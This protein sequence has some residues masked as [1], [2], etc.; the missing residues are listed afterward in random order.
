MVSFQ[1]S[2]SCT[3]DGILKA[4]DK[5]KNYLKVNEGDLLPVFVFDEIGLAE[6]SKYNPLKVLHNLLEVENC[7]IAFVGISN[8]RLDASK[9][10]RAVYLARPDPDEEDLKFTALCIYSQICP[11][12]K[13][14]DGMIRNLAS[15]YF[16]LKHYFKTK[17]PEYSDFYGLRDFYHLIK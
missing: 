10:N 7:E 11:N 5:A 13:T 4:Y 8:W 16:S 17:R 2:D 12:I 14:H 9:M 6:L 3:S 15:S 1:G